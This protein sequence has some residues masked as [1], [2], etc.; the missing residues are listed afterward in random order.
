MGPRP[1]GGNSG[2]FGKREAGKYLN[3]VAIVEGKVSSIYQSAK[4]T[5]LNSRPQSI[6]RR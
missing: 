1:L 6:S 3:Q 5:I 4:V 2:N